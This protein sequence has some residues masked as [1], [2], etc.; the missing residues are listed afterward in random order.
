MNRGVPRGKCRCPREIYA[1]TDP[2]GYG[3]TAGSSD[4]DGDD[5][6]ED[7]HDH[8]GAYPVIRL[9]GRLI[10]Q[11]EQL[12]RVTRR[13]GHRSGR[14][15]L[16][17]HALRRQNG[18]LSCL[19]RGPRLVRTWGSG[20]KSRAP[21]RTRVG[22]VSFER[23]GWLPPLSLLKFKLSTPPT[24][25]SANPTKE[26][27]F[28]VLGIPV[29][30]IASVVVTAIALFIACLFRALSSLH[31]FVRS[32]LEMMAVGMGAAAGKYLIGLLI[33]GVVG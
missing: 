15:P 18:I 31:P 25:P 10:N 12:V 27:P 2:R 9:R 16:A 20:R 32:G 1:F 22:G 14:R 30:V 17:E 24:R 28:R 26:L 4:D 6:Q 23:R 3:E 11:S 21:T 7:D 13:G 8:S 5:H 29:A 33:G 19:V